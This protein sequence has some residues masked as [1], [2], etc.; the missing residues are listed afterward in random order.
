MQTDK[1]AGGA[2]EMIGVDN[3][4]YEVNMVQVEP[5]KAVVR[6]HRGSYKEALDELEKMTQKVEENALT[7]GAKPIMLMY[8]D[9]NE[10]PEKECKADIGFI[11]C[12][13]LPHLFGDDYEAKTLEGAFVS[14]V[15]REKEAGD[16]GEV[17]E[18]L[19][20]TYIPKIHV[21]PRTTQ[22]AY[23]VQITHTVP[24]AE[25]AINEVLVPVHP[26]SD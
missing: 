25:I 14:A 23:S 21:D 22:D 9:P 26:H 19:R 1:E 24:D 5:V 20:E 7:V 2:Q 13:P 18:Y 12:A 10:C 15:A 16:L 11:N 8:D 4:P 3:P 6:K 17:H